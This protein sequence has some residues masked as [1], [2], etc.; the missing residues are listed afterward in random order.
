MG[1]NFKP[2][3]QDIQAEAAELAHAKSGLGPAA[4]PINVP[5]C[6]KLPKTKW[7]KSE[8]PLS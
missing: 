6:R 4:E 5:K 7:R 8:L 2:L 3:A 1:H